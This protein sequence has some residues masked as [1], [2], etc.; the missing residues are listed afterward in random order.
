MSK[1]E[2]VSAAINELKKK[3]AGAWEDARN[4]A[5]KPKGI[6]QL[7]GGINRGIG[8]IYGADFKMSEDKGKGSSPRVD[9]KFVVREPKNFDGVQQTKFYRFF[10]STSDKGKTVSQKLDEFAS[11]IQLLGIVT[12]GTDVDDIPRLLEELK[13]NRPYFY[14][15]TWTPPGDGAFTQVFIQG[16]ATDY[17]PAKDEPEVRDEPEPTPEPAPASVQPPKAPPKAPPRAAATPPKSPPKAPPRAAAAPEP[18]PEPVPEP[19]PEPEPEVAPVKD[20]P[21]VKDRY[22]CVLDGQETTVEVLEVQEDKR[23]CT[24]LDES[25]NKRWA[26]VSWAM[27]R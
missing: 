17:V 2:S 6:V 12:A 1:T 23:T 26:K 11:D 3:A 25:T 8:R 5:P 20:A 18:E 21:E 19:V 13:A 16:L 14:F 10:D 27:L 9:L 22:S 7:P 4:V 24:V 15:N